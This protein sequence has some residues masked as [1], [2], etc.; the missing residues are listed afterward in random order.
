[1]KKHII[2]TLITLL[3]H[4]LAFS[5]D[6]I[7][8]KSG[9]TIKA[10]VLEV[11]TDEVKYKKFENQ[12]GP[13]Y[14][15]LKTEIVLISYEN[16]TKDIFSEKME[17]ADASKSSEQLFMQGQADAKKYYTGYKTGGTITLG[18][19]L[20][21]PLLGLIPATIFSSNQ[22]SDLGQNNPNKNL[23]KNADYYDGYLQKVKKINNTRAWVNWG[24]S[25]GIWV[26]AITALT[27]ASH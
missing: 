11:T 18:V 9:E 5:Q 6:I 24:I 1:M 2:T 3:T 15:V 17:E 10:K 27:I 25:T 20:L 22:P 8:K 13:I 4:I 16:G 26:G 21:N 14:S 7:T 23:L 12:N 19:T